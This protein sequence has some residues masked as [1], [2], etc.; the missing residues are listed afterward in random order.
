[1]LQMAGN[2]S[3]RLIM[4]KKDATLSQK[5]PLLTFQLRGEYFQLAL[6]S[7]GCFFLP[8][9]TKIH[10]PSPEVY[11]PT[12]FTTTLLYCQCVHWLSPQMLSLCFLQVAEMRLLKALRWGKGG[13]E[14]VFQPTFS[15]TKRPLCKGPWK[16]LNGVSCDDAALSASAT[17]QDKHYVHKNPCL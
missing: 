9:S 4:M 13:G 8:T 17:P 3:V 7:K 15:L 16:S 2:L 6:F 12:P 1:M 11:I 5:V 10:P 14:K